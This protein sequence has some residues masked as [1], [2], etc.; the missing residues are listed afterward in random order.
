VTGRIV[1]L[2]IVG[3]L[4]GMLAAGGIGVRVIEEVRAEDDAT[5]LP[6][7]NV[8]STTPPL[9][10][11]S[12]VVPTSVVGTGSSVGIEYEIISLAPAALS[13]SAGASTIYPRTWS[14]T[15]ESGTVDGGPDGGDARVALFE[16]PAGTDASGILAVEIINPLVTYPF[17]TVFE[18]SEVNSSA[19]IMEGVRVELASISRGSEAT[20]VQLELVAV[21]ARDLAFTVEGVGPGWSPELVQAGGPTIELIWLEDE[22]PDVLTFR[23]VGIQWIELEGVFPVSVRDLR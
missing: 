14:L 2:T 13:E 11:S 19:A 12:V 8:S 23:A 10:G 6:A 15:T 16:L 20:E 1:A 9:I 4:V 5:S 22:L 21:D 7:A 3:F 17:D 18:L